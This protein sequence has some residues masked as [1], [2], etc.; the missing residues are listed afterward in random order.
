MNNTVGSIVVG[1]NNAYNFF[2][3]CYSSTA[4][5]NYIYGRITS[6]VQ[7]ELMG[8]PARN[9][10]SHEGIPTSNI[11]DIGGLPDPFSYIEPINNP[12]TC[13]NSI[14]AHQSVTQVYRG[15][16]NIPECRSNWDIEASGTSN[17]SNIER[18]S[19]GS[20]LNS[21]NWLLT[22]TIQLKENGSI[23]FR[24]CYWAIFMRSYIER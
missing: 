6:V 21:Y 16:S 22:K 3:N 5:D 13:E 18:G 15:E 24:T 17:T 2:E 14:L 23:E 10:F 1:N 19:I 8:S 7:G 20:L 9:C 4:F 11:Q 12:P